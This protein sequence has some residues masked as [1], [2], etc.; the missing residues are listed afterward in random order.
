MSLDDDLLAA[1]LYLRDRVILG[2]P[3]VVSAAHR[4]CIHL[5]TDASYEEGKGGLGAILFSSSGLILRWVSKTL[6]ADAVASLNVECKK[7]PLHRRWI[8]FY[9]HCKA[10]C[11]GFKTKQGSFGKHVCGACTCGQG[12][13]SKGGLDEA[14]VGSH[15]LKHTTL[16]WSSKFG[17]DKYARTLLGHHSTGKRSLEA[18]ARD[19]LAPALLDYCKMLGKFAKGSSCQTAPDLEGLSPQGPPCQGP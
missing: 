4:N 13:L 7:T 6:S 3:R 18:Y 12:I 15:S 1:L 8:E 9:F 11:F 10:F 19:I 17:M 5:F 14:G 16:A 2:A